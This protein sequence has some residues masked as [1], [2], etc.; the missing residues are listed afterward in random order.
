MRLVVAVAMRRVPRDRGGQQFEI[1]AT[2]A[3]SLP[4]FIVIDHAASGSCQRD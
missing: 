3:P 2:R 4:C 1:G